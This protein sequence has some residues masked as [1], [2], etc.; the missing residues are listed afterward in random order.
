MKLA[1]LFLSSLCL[2][3]CTK[4]APTPNNNTTPNGATPSSTASNDDHDHGSGS[5]GPSHELGNAKIGSF[6]VR[7]ARDEG[8][9]TPGQ[10]APIDVWLTG[11]DLTHVVAVR[12]WIGAQDAT[13]SMKAKA[14]IENPD[15][16]NHWHTHAL[17]PDPMPEGSMLWVE[18]ETSD[19][20]HTG[21]FDLHDH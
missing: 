4:T 11:G 3:A 6:D 19:G 12:F 9:I 2:V 20:R 5:H 1:V 15:Q 18:I 13:G 17:I 8:Q 16:P 10:D 14:D 21:S 7:A